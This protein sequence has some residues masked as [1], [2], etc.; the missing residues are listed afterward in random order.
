MRIYGK[1]VDAT[2]SSSDEAFVELEAAVARPEEFE[3]LLGKI[4]GE[5]PPAIAVVTARGRDIEKEVVSNRNGRFAF[6]VPK[7]VYQV[8]ARMAADG[9]HEEE[10]ASITKRI[11]VVENHGTVHLDLHRALVVVSGQITDERGRPI[12]NAKVTG[13][14]VPVRESGL[15]DKISAVSDAEGRYELNGF[16]PLNI[17]RVAG[18]LSGGNLDSPGT[19][20]TQVEIR[21]EANHYVQKREN[22]PRIPLVTESRVEDARRLRKTLSRMAEAMGHGSGSNEMTKRDLP[23]NRGNTITDIDLVLQQDGP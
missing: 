2:P 15:I 1:V 13:T 23:S 6:T 4:I 9:E 14:A 5:R 7:G 8:S 16:A 11:R 3:R 21:V 22:V 12:P 10:R 17:Y 18:Y 19:L 20:Y